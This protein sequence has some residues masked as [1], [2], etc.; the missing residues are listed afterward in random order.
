VLAPRGWPIQGLGVL[1]QVCT[2]LGE[3]ALKRQ[4][5][6]LQQGQAQMREAIERERQARAPVPLEESLDIRAAC[7]AAIGADRDL[8]TAQTLVDS[9]IAY[10][11]ALLPPM[12]RPRPTPT[13]G[14]YPQAALR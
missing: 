14:T 8:R 12:P 11:A 5:A 13:D 7:P 1:P 9:P 6:A 4:L 10:A 3:P 2:S